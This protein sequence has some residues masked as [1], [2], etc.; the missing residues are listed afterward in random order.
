MKTENIGCL[1][2]L[3]IIGYVQI[4]FGFLTYAFGDENEV[5]GY[6]DWSFLIIGIIVPIFIV[7]RLYE[8]KRITNLFK[9][10]YQVIFFISLISVIGIA[11]KLFKDGFGNMEDYMVATITSVI[12]L[13][14]K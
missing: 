1:G 10:T 9:L 4:G 12:S 5:F 8:F 6:L 3:S 7:G 13:Q 11:G 2:W 14:I